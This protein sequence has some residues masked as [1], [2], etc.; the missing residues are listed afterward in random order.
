MRDQAA[1]LTARQERFVQ[2]YLVDLNATRAAERAGY[3]PKAAPST[4]ARLKNQPRVKARIETAMAERLERTRIRQDR[5]VMELARLAFSDICEFADWDEGGVRIRDSAGMGPGQS[6]CI[7]EIVETPGKDGRKLRVK[8]HGKTR[9]LEV[10][11]RH[12]GLFEK[13]PRQAEGAVIRV[14]TRIPE[15]DWDGGE[16]PGAGAPPRDPGFAPS[17]AVP[18]REDA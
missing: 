4:G 18:L 5:V 1:G 11:C 13:V 9:A 6:A 17:G 16:P 15:P 12:L 8:L 10:L 3:S 2:E 14:V 7:A